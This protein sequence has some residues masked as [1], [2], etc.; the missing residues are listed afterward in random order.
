[1]DD[2]TYDAEQELGHYHEKGK[3]NVFK[4]KVK[5]DMEMVG[6]AGSEERSYVCPTCGKG[7][8]TKQNL[9]VHY[10][11]FKCNQCDYQTRRQQILKEHTEVDH[12][13]ISYSCTESDFKVRRPGSVR[14]HL[15]RT[16]IKKKTVC[17]ECISETQ[18]KPELR[19]HKQM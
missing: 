9:S 17:D 18:T 14:G 3:R 15:H 13:G 6:R 19:I 4:C 1:M 5:Q 2:K 16:H 7:C 12:E 11:T 8:K 10:L